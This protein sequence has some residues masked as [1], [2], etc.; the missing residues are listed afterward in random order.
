MT[1]FEI[2]R[3]LKKY[4]K[5]N[6]KLSEH[7]LGLERIPEDKA[8]KVDAIIQNIVPEQIV[9][10]FKFEDLKEKYLPYLYGDI[11]LQV[12]LKLEK[13]EQKL[14][15]YQAKSFSF[16][17]RIK[18]IKTISDN[19]VKAACFFSEST[20]KSE[21][22]NYSPS[23]PGVIKEVAL[24]IAKFSDQDK[25]KALKQVNEKFKGFLA[26]SLLDIAE[27]NKVISSISDDSLKLATFLDVIKENQYEVSREAY[28]EVAKSFK[29]DALKLRF[30]GKY[31]PNSGSIAFKEQYNEFKN[32]VETFSSDQAILAAVPYAGADNLKA[33]ILRLLKDGQEA[34][35]LIALLENREEFQ[36]VFEN[37]SDEERLK[38]VW[39][40]RED[41]KAEFISKLQ[42]DD[43]KISLLNTLNSD[44]SKSLV[45]K[46][47]KN[48]E[49]RTRALSF[50][51]EP[52]DRVD[53][54]CTLDYAIKEQYLKT[55]EDEELKQLIIRS[56]DEDK[57]KY[58]CLGYINSQKSIINIAFSFK[59]SNYK[60]MMLDLIA[61]EE[62]RKRLVLE[63]IKEED[64]IESSLSH[65][66]DE[67]IKGL[68]IS[69]LND[70]LKEKCLA[71]ITSESA[72]SIIITSFSTDELK[73][74]YIDS[75]TS[76]EF[77]KDISLSFTKDENKFNYLSRII[78]ESLRTN[79]IITI[80]AD[81]L[82]AQ[83]LANITDK[84]SAF[85][86]IERISSPDYKLY[87]LSQ[88]DDV[89][90]IKEIVNHMDKFPDKSQY[91][92]LLIK[93]YADKL[94]LN[95]DHLKQMIANFG[96]ITL[97]KLDSNNIMSLINLE[98]EAFMKYMAM[99]S[100]KSC[101]LDTQTILAVSSTM[102]NREF[103]FTNLETL[104][105][106]N[107]LEGLINEKNIDG[108]RQILVKITE[109]MDILPIL[110]QNGLDL[111]SLIIN[112]LSDDALVARD[113]LT[114]L[115]NITDKYIG[116]KKEAYVKKR[117][118]GILTELNVP[119]HYDKNFLIKN[120]FANYDKETI[121]EKLLGIDRNDSKLTSDHISLLNNAEL[122]AFCVDFKKNPSLYDFSVFS[123]EIKKALK[124]FGEIMEIM[125]EQRN[126]APFG[127]MPNYDDA[128]KVYLPQKA[129]DEELLN[130]MIEVDTDQFKKHYVD[131][132]DSYDKLLKVIENYKL[133]GWGNTFQ[134]LALKSKTEFDTA[135]LSS[136]IN[137]Y[138][139]IY[140]KLEE[141]QKLGILKDITLFTILDK[142]SAYGS[143]S[144]KYKVL[145]GDEDFILLKSNPPGN[146]APASF[147][148]RINEAVKKVP[149]MYK[150]DFVTVPPI[151]ETLETAKGKKLNV[152]VGNFSN[153]INLTY[154]ERTGACMRIGGPGA[155]LFN[156]CLE[157]DNGF[158]IR[159][160]NP[161]T[162]EFV[163]RVSGFRNGNT[164]F[165]NQLRLSTID[166]YSDKDLIEITEK[167]AKILI[168]KSQSSELPIDNVVIS[169]GFAMQ[170]MDH[171][172][173]LLGVD[174]IKK[175]L[176]DFYSDVG[177]FA[178]PLASSDQDN[179]LVPV[180]LNIPNIPKYPV[181]RDKT[182]YCE[183]PLEISVKA[184]RLEIID[185]MLSGVDFQ[186]ASGSNEEQ[187]KQL[188]A[189]YYG[190]DWYL[191]ISRDGSLIKYIM[192]NAKNKE[193]AEIEMQNIINKLQINEGLEAKV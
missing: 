140:P 92:P 104:T 31:A 16:L 39:I 24:E 147:E 112:L 176:G 121:L 145:F 44:A 73:C 82:K 21:G 37:G 66:Q 48:G 151:D 53:I 32:I 87:L 36:R 150:R 115:H 38:Y 64:K 18:I 172:S 91:F 159:F 178:I 3:R 149:I 89:E 105:I 193:I 166:S 33:D 130:V 177:S 94:N 25:V 84:N 8:K 28:I 7:Y 51:S 100:P 88:M 55:L 41:Q 180:V 19:E 61:D 11:L 98:D 127:E 181:Q 59:D 76:P 49:L 77:I 144:S 188:S 74:K 107:Q 23:L 17:D 143:A 60:L 129:S 34:E 9:R 14:E 163:S 106:F 46:S 117:M 1:N 30:L 125:Y 96:Y 119:F 169:S 43:I 161:N 123:L 118:D 133:L 15:F 81:K 97:Q 6:K 179:K 29:A 50:V 183:D 186:F 134:S 136:L 128:K 4:F 122:L 182:F 103:R 58:Q 157:N 138:Y 148:T 40:F 137:S 27:F 116:I 110:E 2:R 167:T 171:K 173:I 95:E 160:S 13:D 69:T 154:G 83:A 135:V 20:L 108:I 85:K 139:A 75:I 70:A 141:K 67:N 63:S 189:L 45:I 35:R 101:T 71:G 52:K 72:K 152:N 162:G 78:D 184:D 132:E 185:Q 142:A 79:V 156:F 54:V 153:P 158:H 191:G 192:G 42:S 174:N 175:G 57:L 10:A 190:E 99:F 168:E 113:S 80:N 111:N 65:F 62:E 56:I 12:T 86:I 90:K 170:H 126:Y 22:L 120:L 93:I 131:S 165:L 187:D 102:V 114:F 109:D 5:K 124:T 146:S 47:L 68:I 155:S 164:I 26:I